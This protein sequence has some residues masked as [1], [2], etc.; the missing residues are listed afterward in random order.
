MIMIM[1]EHWQSVFANIPPLS[2]AKGA[3]LFLRGDR[4]TALHLVRTG[5]IKL[6]RTLSDGAVLTLHEASEGAVV[7][8]ASLFSDHYHCD[9][10]VTEDATIA[11]LPR[12]TVFEAL[13]SQAVSLPALQAALAQVQELRARVEVLR[14]RR[15]SERL[16]AYL[17]LKGP[18]ERGHWVDVAD[19][20]GV[21]PPALYRELAKRRSTPQ[22]PALKT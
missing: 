22:R 18:P 17:H 13:E 16:D 6:I 3:H 19:W 14:L 7:A 11:S 4:V 20:I 15:T 21:T 1:F 12:N 9:A 5:K 8:E 2:L 10:V